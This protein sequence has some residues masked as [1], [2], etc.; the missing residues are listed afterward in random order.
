MGVLILLKPHLNKY[1]L[2]LSNGTI[3]NFIKHSWQAEN[4]G[5]IDCRGISVGEGG[6]L[7]VGSKGWN[8]RENGKTGAITSGGCQGPAVQGYHIFGS[9]NQR[10]G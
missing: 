6:I 1:H 4:E 5:G 3:D 9:P 10:V 2:N 8:S 7:L